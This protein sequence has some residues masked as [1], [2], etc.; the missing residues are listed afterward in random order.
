MN[1]ILEKWL[2]ERQAEDKKARE[3]FL[4]KQGLFD[5]A[6]TKTVFKDV[7][8]NVL[9]E[10]EAKQKQ[11]TGLR[12]DKEVTYEALDLT[13][14]EYKQVLTYA[15]PQTLNSGE[16]TDHELLKII[17]RNT[18]IVSTLLIIYVVLSVIIGIIV[19]LHYIIS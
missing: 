12:V 2:A 5:S 14:E 7:M 13:D 6:K 19:G 10:D 17:S 11:A 16:I 18:G 9:T 1:P 3:A 4:L 15:Q 8:G